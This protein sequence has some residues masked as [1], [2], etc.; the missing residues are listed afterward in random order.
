[1]DTIWAEKKSV[2]RGIEWK[3]K[4][5]RWIWLNGG[6]GRGG[7]SRGLVEAAE[8]MEVVDEMEAAEKIIA[9]FDA[10]QHTMYSF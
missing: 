4:R 3:R 8:E 6:C 2:D 5:V 10:S 7:S 1:M 9:C